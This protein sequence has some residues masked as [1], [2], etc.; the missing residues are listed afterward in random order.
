MA[1]LDV[2][3]GL[4]S[5]D[6][7]QIIRLLTE[8]IGQP[9]APFSTIGDDAAF[10][11]SR[12]GLVVLKSD[13]LVGQ[14]D[15]P[16]KMKLWQAAR[17]SVV[18]CASDFAAKGVKPVAVTTSLGLPRDFTKTDVIELAEGFRRAKDE[19]GIEIIGGDTNEARDLV[20]D[21]TMVGFAD[22]VVKRKGAQA[23]DVVVTSGRF[24]YSASGIKIAVEGMKAE[25]GFKKRALD[26][27]FMPKPRLD[28]GLTMKD[29]LSASIDSSDGLALS[30]Y[31]I[32]EAGKV[33][34]EIDNLPSDDPVR[35]FC[36]TNGIS[37][38]DVSLYGG[39]EYE[40]VA[41]VPTKRLK[42]A[43]RR[44]RRMHLD[45]IVIGRVSEDSGNV[46]MKRDRKEA[47]VE[48]RGWVHFR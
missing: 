44:A 37:V 15:V 48:R 46:T 3:S 14:T 2:E 5:L 42:D 30:L 43:Q 24:G 39:E 12:R 21:C 28:F 25:E 10:F 27:V 4:V 38:E 20:I 1:E 13:M 23:G 34:I 9:K 47:V 41:T 17:K 32:T 19:F 16:S 29:F 8:E 26:S 18:M 6:E 22:T 40:I 11:P 33:G 35:N 31:Q 45:L 36:K 7:F